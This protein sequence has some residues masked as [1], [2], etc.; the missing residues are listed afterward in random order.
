MNAAFTW[1]R[2]SPSSRSAH[3][4]WL[5]V[6]RPAVARPAPDPRSG[7]LP[8]DRQRRCAAGSGPAGRWQNASGR[9]ARPRGDPAQLL[10]LVHLG[11]R[12]G[13]GSGKAQVDGRLEERLTHFAKPKLLIVDELGYLPLETHAAHLFF[14]LVIRRYEQGSILITSNRASANGAASSAI[15]SSPP[16]SWTACCTTATSSPSAATVTACVKN[17]ARGLLQK[18]ATAK[19]KPAAQ[20]A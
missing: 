4:R 9:R 1:P 2:A 10:G 11:A 18:P 14:K 6:R 13:H 7:D 12:A 17:A 19:T 5:R 16:R 15:R 8:L 20:A 3:A